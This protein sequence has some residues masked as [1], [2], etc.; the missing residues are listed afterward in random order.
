MVLNSNGLKQYQETLL[1]GFA[2][3]LTRTRELK[4]PAAAFAEST[5]A[6]F[7]HS[8]PYHPL[9]GADSVPYVC[10]RVPTGG[11]KT[12]IGGQAIKTVNESFLATEHSLILWLVPSDPI[13]EQTLYALKTDGELLHE[14]MQ[15]LFGAVNVLDITEALNLQPATLNSGNTIIVATMQSF[16]RDTAEG[17][18]VNRQN[19]ALMPHF[20][21]ASSV[22]K[23]LCSLLDVIRLRR[24]FVIVDE[25]HNQG[26]P[27]A[28]D[29]LVRFEPSCILELTATPDRA[30]QPSNVLRS[31]S[32]STLQAEDMLKLP[33][34]LAIHP[35]WRVS[36]T[37]AIARVRRLER[38]AEEEQKLTGEIIEPVVMLIQAE[39]RAQDKETFTPERVRQHLI[40]DF[41]I[42]PE[43]IAIATGALDELSGRKL[44]DPDFPQ[45]IITVDKLREGWD[46]P[47][48]YVLFSF[49][50]TTSATAVE[51]VLGRVLRMPHV[52][53]KQH[54]AL[55]RSYAYVVS[56]ELAATVQNLRD[57]LVQSGFERMETQDLIRT[58][59][60]D[61]PTG[62]LFALQTDL[63]IPLPEVGAKV[64]L[65]DADAVAALP[66]A[67]REKV[68]V[69]PE[70][71]TLTVK[72]GASAIQL[73]QIADTFKQPEVA[74]T[75]REIMDTQMAVR[76]APT[77]YVK[78][79]SEKGESARVPLLGIFQHGFF[80]VFDETP[81]LDADWELE[82]F[83]PQLTEGEF[84]HD[85]EAM[86][87]A[88]LNISQ[89]E[90]VECDLYDK[91]DSQLALFGQELGWQ[92][93]DLVYWL[94][95]NLYFPYSD[96]GQKAA[97]L[98]TSVSHLIDNR[99]FTLA[100]LAYRKFR[101]RGA[102]ERKLASG[103]V[104]AK[105]RVFNGLFDDESIFDVRDEHSIVFESGRYGYDTP[106]TGL[107]PLKRHFF[108]VIGNLK[109]NGEEF[110]CAE[111]IANQLDGVDWWVR[112][113]EKKS[114][115]FW[116]QTASD[117]FYPDFVMRMKNGIIVAIEYK[118]SHIAGSADSNEKKRIGELWAKR[119]HGRCRFAW[120]ENKNWQ[121]IKDALL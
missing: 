46:C 27:L 48:A 69:S 101:L 105:Q 62:D 90:K 12:R 42:S 80:D 55:N 3:F 57:G 100:E 71:G 2:A 117:K 118:G 97:W 39:R 40:D 63:I 77:A 22:Q 33:L 29:T 83:D 18:R 35:E 119:S 31:V 59:L 91:L 13:R 93:T 21:G 89:L 74:K 17:L 19:G 38:E 81:L 99:G 9:P 8:L 53:R 6:Y 75:V 88:S 52:I 54:E 84:A 104:L 47:N 68:E 7:G 15:D 85:V 11:G 79:P 34:E 109:C 51:Q 121:A 96:G 112:N 60:D 45:F 26:T 70:A 73:K 108:P 110:E 1:E 28:V 5:K 86:R 67:L 107:I 43:S 116:L 44:G 16:K 76:A 72:G 95:R 36:L 120:V 98:N 24:P 115:S 113:V 4:S 41:Q 92:A 25:A 61:T 37:E 106:Y 103:L 87:R 102:L 14:D 23:G 32:A 94:D 56:G 49:R 20:N 50:N 114:T 78:T 64:V 111:F 58:R 10:L 30:S 65:P 66:K 82:E